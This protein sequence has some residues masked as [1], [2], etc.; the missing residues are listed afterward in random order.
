MKEISCTRGFGIITD[1]QTG[2]EYNVERENTVE[3]SDAVAHRLKEGYSGVVIADID[4][5]N[6]DICGVEMTDGSICHRP[7]DECG[8]HG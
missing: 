1:P 6:E 8:Y 5:T 4:E 3:V 2:T 7:K